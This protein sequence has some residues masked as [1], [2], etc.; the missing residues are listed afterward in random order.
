[1]GFKTIVGYVGT[2]E[3]TPDLNPELSRNERKVLAF[4]LSL[5]AGETDP[6]KKSHFRRSHETI[7]KATGLSQ[8]TV[9]RI[10]RRLADL[11]LISWSSGYGGR[12]GAGGSKKA[13]CMPNEYR[14]D[15]DIIAGQKPGRDGETRRYCGR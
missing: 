5:V 2:G 12:R 3:P 6:F 15:L 13:A 4:Y 9:R 7:A 1:M 10:N 8:R 14:L 11:D